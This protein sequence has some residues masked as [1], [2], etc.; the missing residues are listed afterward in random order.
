MMRMPLYLPAVLLTLLLATSSANAQVFFQLHKT[1]HPLND[2]FFETDPAFSDLLRFASRP[3]SYWLDYEVD[4][5]PVNSLYESIEQGQNQTQ[6]LLA[7]TQTC[8]DTYV[9]LTDFRLSVDQTR[10]LTVSAN[11]TSGDPRS[12][13]KH[14]QLPSLAASDLISAN[15]TADH[16]LRI[17][18]PHLSLSDISSK[19]IPVTLEPQPE[20]QAPACHKWMPAA[21]EGKEGAKGLSAGSKLEIP[22]P[23]DAEEAV[24]RAHLTKLEQELA[25]LKSAL[26]A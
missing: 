7:V 20:P 11:I 25:K 2:H 19:D 22:E 12:F 1:S 10:R 14:Y 16:V 8:G 3:D 5:T 4:C 6:L 9:P 13:T 21:T 17:F 26:A 18:I 23:E 24:L 15:Y